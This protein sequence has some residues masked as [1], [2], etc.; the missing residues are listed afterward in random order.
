MDIIGVDFAFIAHAFALP[1]IIANDDNYIICPDINYGN[2]LTINDFIDT[3]NFLYGLVE[4]SNKGITQIANNGIFTYTPITFECNSDQFSYQLCDV[5]TAI[6]DTAVVTL[7]FNDEQAPSLVNIPLSL[8]VSCDEKI[9]DPASVSAFDNCPRIG[10]NLDEIS[11]QGEDGCSQHD[12]T[13]TRTWTATDL[14][15]N[16]NYDS[17]TIDIQDVE[18]P[19]IFRIYTL[20]NGKKLIGGIAEFTGERWKTI[21]FPINFE[22]IPLVFSQIITNKETSPAIV[23][24]RKISKS[25]FEIHL[26]EEEK[27]DGIHNRESVA[28]IAIES[29][30]QEG[31]YPLVAGFLE[32]DDQLRNIN[33]PLNYASIPTLFTSIQTTNEEDPAIIKYKDLSKNGVNIQLIEEASN[34]AE[35]VH[36]QEK[37]GYIAIEKAGDLTDKYGD[38]IG[39]VGTTMADG[40]WK[41]VTMNQNYTNPIV[42]VNSANNVEGFPLTHRIRNVSPNSFDLQIQKWNY[43]NFIPENTPISYLVLEGS[44][45]LYTSNYCRLGTD[46]LINGIDIIAI[47]NCDNTVD[48]AYR[49]YS[50][51]DGAQLVTDR[52]WKS[53]DECG[54]QV[55]YSQQISCEGIAVKIQSFL[56]GALIGSVEEG[57][58]RDDLRKKG[59]LPTKE[60]YTALAN[61]QHFGSGGGEIIDTNL[62]KITGPDAIVDWVLLE[63]KS[64]ENIDKIIAT[65]S[66]LIQRDGDIISSSGDSVIVFANV[67][68]GDYY[69]TVRHR[70]HIGITSKNIYSFSLNNIPQ[71][72]FRDA[73]TATNGNHPN[74]Q[75]GNINA[76]WSGDLNGDNKIIYQG[77]LNDPFNMFLHIILDESNSHYLTNYITKGYTQKDF[78]LDGSV[79]YQGPNNDRSSLLFNTILAH[80]QNISLSANYIISTIRQ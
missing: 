58:M 63:L 1:N 13:L 10:I 56:Q 77:P 49:E 40:N 11:S 67:P 79:I 51:F 20:S 80:P 74:I 59:F 7:I 50:Q 60:P 39:E 53:S 14:C 36:S 18:A 15:G 6:C 21:P 31:E 46:G 16:T 48:L 3:D 28:W 2:K 27:N 44:I 68:F 41:K 45:P 5:N 43:L 54:N 38:I 42:I 76:Q 71:L 37:I 26:Q 62:L 78:N 66:G 73:F 19:D 12:Y 4:P 17:Q 23:Q 47:D 22:S 9:P 75:I 52:N 25:Q 65:S 72:D 32:I 61:F 30:I 57:L 24:N 33:F 55:S 35:T 8:T 64:A 70:N 69:I 34:D 29:G